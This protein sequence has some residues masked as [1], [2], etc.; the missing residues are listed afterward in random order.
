MEAE[1]LPISAWAYV[2]YDFKAVPVDYSIVTTNPTNAEI[3]KARWQRL[4]AV[5]P[6]SSDE[7]FR[8]HVHGT[9]VHAAARAAVLLSPWLVTRVCVFLHRKKTYATISSLCA[10]I[11]TSLLGDILHR[12]HASVWRHTLRLCRPCVRITNADEM[13]K[14]T[15]D[16]TSITATQH[17]YMGFEGVERDGGRLLLIVR[18]KAN[19]LTY[20][21]SVSRDSR[22][23]ADHVLCRQRVSLEI[24]AS[25]SMKRH[26]Y[27]RV[28]GSNT[29]LQ[30]V[31][32]G[33]CCR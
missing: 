23:L 19:A 28:H 1:S 16:V 8:L 22:T 12:T 25:K 6:A 7:R 3:G 4:Y 2:S 11:R 33:T 14:D 24:R 20:V 10:D 15:E 13:A 32:V 5:T 30:L 27:I 31:K 9:K 29:L 26:L 17:N 21:E 18:I